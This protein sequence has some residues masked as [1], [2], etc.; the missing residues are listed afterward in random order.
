MGRRK[1]AT[2]MRRRESP[3]CLLFKLPGE[4]RNTIYGMV[5]ESGSDTVNI[6]DA[7]SPMEDGD[8]DAAT[9]LRKISASP[10]SSALVRSCQQLRQESQ[11][12]FTAAYER[13]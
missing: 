5:F 9:S 8:T 10:P 13:Y 2:V 12:F 1:R 3:N 6:A 4:L 11:C 7:F